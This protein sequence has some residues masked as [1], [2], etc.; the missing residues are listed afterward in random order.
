MA[1]LTTKGLIFSGICVLLFATL[2]LVA[3]QLGLS[4]TALSPGL[5]EVDKRALKEFEGTFYITPVLGSK[6]G[7]DEGQAYIKTLGDSTIYIYCASGYWLCSYKAWSKFIGGYARITGS[8]LTT[9]DGRTVYVPLRLRVFRPEVLG[10]KGS[11]P[12]VIDFDSDILA[13]EVRSRTV[14]R[15]VVYLL[16]AVIAWLAFVLTPPRFR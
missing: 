3:R 4:S 11:G 10:V 15:V 12:Q 5:I 2:Q 8:P 13:K 14:E 9:S 1:T 6:V 7:A 16:I